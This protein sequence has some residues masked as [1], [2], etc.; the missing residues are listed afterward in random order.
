MKH[1][2]TYNENSE[3]PKWVICVDAFYIFT[4][5]TQGKIYKCIGQ[6]HNPLDSKREWIT[7]IDDINRKRHLLAHRFI[8]L[9]QGSIK[10]ST[11]SDSKY[12]LYVGKDGGTCDWE[13]N[14]YLKFGKIYKIEHEVKHN[15]H[16]ANGNP[17]ITILLTFIDTEDIY[18]EWGVLEKNCIRLP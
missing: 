15:P 8:D 17:F 6:Y 3:F 11:K 13:S 18:S 14:R 4:G 7:I 1:L 2:K 12:V 16:I 9:P 5:L 10:E